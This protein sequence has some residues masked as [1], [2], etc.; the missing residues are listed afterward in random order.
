[1][2]VREMAWCYLCKQYLPKTKEDV[3]STWLRGHNK[4]LQG[5]VRMPDRY[6]MPLC[7]H[8]NNALGNEFENPAAPLLK[9]LRR[10]RNVVLSEA[11][12]LTIAKWCLLKDLEFQMA[13]KIVFAADGTRKNSFRQRE[14]FRLSLQQM[15]ET[16]DPV[17]HASV[18]IGILGA[19]GPSLGG[20]AP[21]GFDPRAA[22]LTSLYPAGTFV[23]EGIIGRTQD[24]IDLHVERTANDAR[25]T[26]IWPP[27]GQPV[28]VSDRL[29]TGDVDAIL[30]ALRHD[31]VN[32][33]GAFEPTPTM[34]LAPAEAD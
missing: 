26:R 32:R 15:L 34:R 11:E 14:P 8:C 3:V 19:H 23:V 22:R 5:Q 10:G 21:D 4:R 18:R 9:Q 30:Q 20:F 1:M 12:Q 28:L 16:G 24:I 7:S 2:S 13:R 17:P 29:V 6:L 33:V 25:L 27:T 31:P